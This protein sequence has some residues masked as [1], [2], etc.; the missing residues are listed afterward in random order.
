MSKEI[1]IFVTNCLDFDIEIFEPQAIS[2]DSDKLVKL[3]ELKPDC[4]KRFYPK[5]NE[6]VIFKMAKVLK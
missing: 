2:M 4:G 6:I 1:S 5:I 3:G